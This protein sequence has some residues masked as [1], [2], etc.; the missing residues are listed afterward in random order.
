MADR[1][2]KKLDKQNQAPIYSDVL[3]NFNAHPN[4]G[5]LMQ[6]FNAES[7]KR[8]IRNLIMTDKGERPYNSNFGCSI[9]SMLFELPTEFT[10]NQIKTFVQESIKNYEKRAFVEDVVVTISNDEHTYIVD[11]YFRLINSP[12]IHT[13]N[14]KLERAR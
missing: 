10:K 5:I 9:R 4:T 12:E 8:A 14:V 3:I 13:F 7:V 6:K 11:V 1:S 2:D